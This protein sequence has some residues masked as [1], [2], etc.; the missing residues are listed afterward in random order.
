MKAARQVRPVLLPLRAHKRLIQLKPGRNLKLGK[1]GEIAAG[2]FL[3]EK[4]HQLLHVNY[5]CGHKEIDIVSLDKDILVFVEIKARS[6]FSFGFP[7][8][9]VT[10]KKQQLLKAAAEQF[11]LQYP[12]YVQIRFDVISIL[13]SEGIVAEILHFEDAFY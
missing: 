13:F 8:E 12:E 3:Q 2:R 6:N 11:L 4:G 1:S 5:R 9:A 10:A 7:E